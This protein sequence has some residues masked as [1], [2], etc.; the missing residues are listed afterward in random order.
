VGFP[1]IRGLENVSPFVETLRKVYDT[2]VV[3][4]RFFEAPAHFRIALGGKP[5]ILN[6]G[7]SRLGEALRAELG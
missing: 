1:R 7:L 2:G 3:P 4:G 5:E 6:E